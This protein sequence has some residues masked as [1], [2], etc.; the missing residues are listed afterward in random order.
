MARKKKD[1]VL[2]DELEGGPDPLA[3]ERR[4][5]GCGYSAVA[6]VDEAGR[7]PLAGPVVAAAVILDE[8]RDY[9]GVNDSKQL[10]ADERE[11][12]FNLICCRARAVGMSLIGEAEIDRINILQ[13]SLKAMA[14][15]VAGLSAPVDFVL[16]DGP[17]GIPFDAPQLAVKKG[18]RLSL[19]IGA[20]SIVAKV[21][22]DR[23][24]TAYDRF[25]PQYGFALHKGYATKA[26]L[27]A[28][29]DLGPCRIHRMTFR[30]VRSGN[31]ERT[32]PVPSFFL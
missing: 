2:F 32:G 3:L 14:Q 15:A 4:M 10:T 17:F 29:A 18:D 28:L 21:I 9:P 6:G 31:V 8:C 20:A 5:R 12:A 11:R 26:H 22:R 25:F 30:G 16:I 27:E 24:M 7:G 19:S 13:A 1:A 23:I